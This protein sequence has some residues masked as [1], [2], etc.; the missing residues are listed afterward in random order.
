MSAIVKLD[1][2][3][4]IVDF[5]VKEL[6]SPKAMRRMT[7]NIREVQPKKVE[8]HVDEVIAIKAEIVVMWREKKAADQSNDTKGVGK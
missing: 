7:T 6:G 5:V 2:P 1:Y 4:E 8:I 3:Q